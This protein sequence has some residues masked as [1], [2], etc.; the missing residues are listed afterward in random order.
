MTTPTA[1]TDRPARLRS[2]IDRL[3]RWLWGGPQA[4][5]VHLP[6]HERELI[7]HDIGVSMSE[8]ERLTRSRSD[9]LLLYQRLAT[10]ELDGETVKRQGYLRDLERTCALCDSQD[11][12]RHDL[13]ERPD[14]DEWERYC[15]N[16]ET[17]TH[18][19]AEAKA[20]EQ[21]SKS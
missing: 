1:G 7:A 19:A 16:V 10:L 15:P 5:F 11:M 6:E 13:S 18:L 20:R 8:L 12:C 17:L 2:F 4:E 21:G 9:G 3:E 14:S